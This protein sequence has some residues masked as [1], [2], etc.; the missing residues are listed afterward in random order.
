K[1]DLAENAIELTAILKRTSQLAIEHGELHRVVIDLDA[2]NPKAE[3]RLDYLVERCLGS[4]AIARNEALRPDEE[5][6]KRAADR[7]RQTL[8]QLPPDALAVGD[9]DEAMKRTLA[10]A[11]HHV[12]DRQCGPAQEGIT[13]DANG[14]KWG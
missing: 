12:A 13:G 10:V 4:A 3:D 8:S 11:G 6:V 1:A 5:E 9:P 2:T 14:K 7:G